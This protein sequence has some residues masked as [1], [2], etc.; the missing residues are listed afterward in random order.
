MARCVGTLVFVAA[1]GVAVGIGGPW[2]AGA[3]A[4]TIE[5]TF[6]GT[7]SGTLNNVPFSSSSFTIDAISDGVLHQTSPPNAVFWVNTV[8]ASVQ[9]DQLGQFAINSPTS[10]TYWPAFGVF[11]FS[12]AGFETDSSHWL[13]YG[14][15]VTG[16]SSLLLSSFGPLTQGGVQILS[17]NQTPAVQTSG[18]TL[19]LNDALITAT[20]RIIAPAPGSAALLVGAALWTGRRRRR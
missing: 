18:G 16:N 9:I 5:Y 4:D 14:P 15:H 13:I 20:F 19:V 11:G 17:W 1:M 3:R 7:A 2:Q 8:T 6:Q 12:R 10:T